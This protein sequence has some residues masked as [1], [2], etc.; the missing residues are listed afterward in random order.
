MSNKE[1]DK[2]FKPSKAIYDSNYETNETIN[3]MSLFQKCCIILTII[4][5]IYYMYKLIQLGDINL[6]S[7]TG[8]KDIDNNLNNSINA[9]I[10]YIRNTYISIIASSIILCIVFCSICGAIKTNANHLLDID[11]S[12]FDDSV[13]V[14]QNVEEESLDATEESDDNSNTEKDT[15]EN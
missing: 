1:D 7:K 13:I 5:C 9:L 2:K 3:R 15:E 10:S 12:I 8:I 14:E 4:V 11:D 6:N